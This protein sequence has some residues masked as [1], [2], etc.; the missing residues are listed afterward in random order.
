MGA[1]EVAS[2]FATLS[3]R[4]ELSGGLDRAGA[5]LDT[6]GQRMA[7]I[8]GALQTASAPLANFGMDALAVAGDF[9]Q[10]MAEIS[11]R[12]GVTGDALEE[13]R[14]LALQY[15]A[16]TMFSGQQAADAMLQLLTSGQ[17]LEE[18][19][20]TLPA[21]LAGAAA[22]GEALGSTA[23]AVTDVMA[24]FGLVGQQSAEDVTDALTRASGASSATFGEL[25][26]GFGN[27]GPVANRFGLSVE[28]TAATLGV[29]RDNGI[30][31]AEAGT[32]LRS[33]LLN[34]SRDTSDVQEAW[35]EL[36]TSL[37]DSQ[38]NIRDMTVVMSELGAGLQ[39]LPLE[40]QNRLLTTLGGAYGVVALT[41]LTGSDAITHMEGSMAAAASAQEVAEAR[42]NTFQG[43]MDALKGSVETLMIEA[44]TPL[45]N[46]VITPL[47]QQLTPIVNSIADWAAN[48]PELAGGI[49]A[50][51]IA[52]FAL[53][54]ALTILG[55]VLSALA[56][57]LGAVSLPAIAVVAGFVALLHFGGQLQTVLDAIGVAWERIQGG[58]GKI[59]EG[60]Q[61]L[62][63]GGDS[64]AA[65]EKIGSGL[66]EIGNALGDLGL[67]T[68]D[69][70]LTSIEN[71]TGLDLPGAQEILDGIGAALKP[72][73]DFFT[74]VVWPPIASGL[75]SLGAAIMSFLNNVTGAD[76]SGFDEILGALA[77]ALGAIIA[78]LAGA[79][80]AGLEGLSA[81]IDGF[82]QALRN[83][84]S[85]LSAAATGDGATA[86]DLLVAGL[87]DLVE[88]IL[89][90]PIAS[91]DA[92]VGWFND[93]LGTNIPTIGEAV[94]TLRVA[95]EQLI[96]TISTAWANVQ[97]GILNFANNV[98]A[99]LQPVR[100][101][102]NGMVESV[103]SF[104][105]SI[106]LLPAVGEVP[107]GGGGGAVVGW[108]A[109]GGPVTAGMPYV[110]G[111]RGAEMFVPSSS[112]RIV[113]H[114]AM[115]GGGG[116]TVYLT[117]YGSN[118]YELADM[119]QRAMNDRSV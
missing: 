119:L 15:G 46:D 28:R 10:S 76:Y 94:D 118:P 80:G 27:V 24:Q 63:A 100:D 45:M 106:G 42:T 53:G 113:P 8:G 57:L 12:T 92:L 101:F 59:G 32:A 49:L 105:A 62:I 83:L 117:S 70:L 17:S 110:V 54:G 38:G 108:R 109:S 4:D 99:A 81:F 66:S 6:L 103:R 71:L 74:G 13:L 36:G 114:T 91:F 48:N 29:L 72:F 95:F 43:A 52:A 115:P 14:R 9:E 104:L 89:S 97:A 23:D 41:A 11:A 30:R 85:A 50:V 19:K 87:V 68:F 7:A 25:V 26:E 67:T 58:L 20:A 3:L 60:I 21:V 93:L 5:G 102:V 116:V 35:A 44:M 22:S 31:G 107:A 84:I 37:Y 79:L 51:S 40:E 33:M 88:A 1:V 34:M 18:M 56:T 90:V 39:E 47:V 61:T 86:I 64:G 69:A 78:A 82:G 65:L 16:D 96:N 77:T 98:I 73:I 112:G 111:E 55:P 2:L 75:E